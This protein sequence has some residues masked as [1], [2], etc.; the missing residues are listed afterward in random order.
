MLIIGAGLGGLAIALELRRAGIDDFLILEKAADV[1]GVWREN[2]YPGAAVDVPSPYYSFAAEP[3]PDWPRAYSEQPEILAYIRDVVRRNGLRR[4]I[5][6]ET[7][8]L[9]AEHTE[10]R[11]RVETSRAQTVD[12]QTLDAQTFDAQFLVPATGQLSIP[13]LPQIPGLGT[14]AGP[15]FHSARWDHS[16]DLEG[17]SVAVIGTGA[18]AIQIIPRL[19]PRVGRLLVLQRSAPY[20]L[21]RMD[22]EIGPRARRIFRR[23]PLVQRGERLFWWLFGEFWTLAILGNRGV[24]ALFRAAAAILRRIQVR[25]P[26]LRARL[27]PDYPMGCKRVLF[28]SDYYPAM[29]A[30][31]VR[32]ETAGI[33]EI[34]PDGIRTVDGVE[35]QVDVLVFGTGFQTQDFLDSIPIR[36]AGGQLLSECWA[37]GARAY[38]GMAVPGFPNLLI[39]YG[40]NTNLGSGSIIYMLERQARYIRDLIEEMDRRGV[41]S[42]TVRA[43]VEQAYD[44]D[45]Q[46]RLA[47]SAWAGCDSWYKAASGRIASNWP[48][49]VSAYSRRTAKVDLADYHLAGQARSPAS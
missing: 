48:R 4:H 32:L 15:A 28:S 47:S 29:G 6:F 9:G 39:M 34:L 14:F 17:K 13:R 1:G 40:P 49:T 21:P 45:V 26:E 11:W 8:V 38:L 2:T 41:V 35:H 16:V 12:S 44:D 37:D 46:A 7:E 3:N 10:G 33:D 24:A 42:A 19:Q 23:F 22:R 27:T 18:S 30:P 25:D 20:L 5:R 36:G 43:E 31:N